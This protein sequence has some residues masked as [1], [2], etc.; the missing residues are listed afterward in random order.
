MREQGSIDGR[1]RQAQQSQ[2]HSPEETTVERAAAAIL[3]TIQPDT[4]KRHPSTTV[5]PK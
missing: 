1:G 4:G 5:A 2:C 3:V